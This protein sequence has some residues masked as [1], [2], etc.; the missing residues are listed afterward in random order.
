MN[1]GK[2]IIDLENTGYHRFVD[3][4]FYEC[5]RI[6]RDN[7]VNLV[8]LEEQVFYSVE[9]TIRDLHMNFGK[10]EEEYYKNG[11]IKF[12]GFEFLWSR[13]LPESQVHIFYHPKEKVVTEYPLTPEECLKSINKVGLEFKKP[14]KT[15]L[16]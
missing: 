14:K 11:I 7:H 13:Q 4:I 10:D 5:Q 16:C 9:K 3:V 15:K 2:A 12:N 6:S 8:L 1:K